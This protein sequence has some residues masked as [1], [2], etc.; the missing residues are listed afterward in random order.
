MPD[1]RQLRRFIAIANEKSFRRAAARLHVTQPPLSHS[2]RKLEDEIGTPLFVRD[3]RHVEL[4]KAGVVFLE[5]AK[6]LVSQL[7]DAVATTRAVAGGLSG[8]IRIGFFPTS[9]YDVL[10]RILRAFRKKHPEIGLRFSE[11]TT[12]QQPEA[13]HDNRIDVGLFLAPFAEMSGLAQEIFH[14]EPLVV[15]LPEDHALTRR[16]RIG[17]VELKDEPFIFIPPRWGTGYHAQVSHAFTQAGFAPRVVEEVEHLHTMVS[18]VGAGMGVAVGAASLRHFQPPGVAFRDF[19]PSSKLS[20]EFGLA[21]RR[22]DES[23]AVV[24]FRATA[25]KIGSSKTSPARLR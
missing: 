15:A 7:D 20:I 14:K 1:I 6:L 11:L 13:L 23:P 3:R 24:N 10:P 9:T 12:P 21:W 17:L 25:R 5:R 19:K 8:Q 2:I 22:N 4:T 18:L 16:A